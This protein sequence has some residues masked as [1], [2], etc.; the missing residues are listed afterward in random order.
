[1]EP[2]IKTVRVQAGPDRAF[3]LFTTR[4]GEWWPL[5]THSVGA[6]DAIDVTLEGRVGGEIV[7][8]LRDNS[9]SVWGTVTKWDPP[10]VVAFTWHPGRTASQATQVEVSFTADGTGTRVE[11]VHT[12][13][14]A[15][16]AAA[17]NSYDSGWD[18]VLG[19]FTSE[20]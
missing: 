14:E 12:G 19:C 9:T 7:E 10:A 11:L 2:L 6:T 8:T 4:M 1:M 3:A 13:W 17:R 18:F 5:A 16:D 15:R 20:A